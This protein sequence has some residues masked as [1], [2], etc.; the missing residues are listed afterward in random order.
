IQNAQGIIQSSKASKITILTTKQHIIALKKLRAE[1]EATKKA[2][3]IR[4]RKQ[5]ERTGTVRSK[6]IDYDLKAQNQAQRR[7]I[8]LAQQQAN[9]QNQAQ[10]RAIKLAQ[11]QA[12]AQNQ[13]QRRSIKLAQKQ[14]SAMD[15]ASKSIDRQRSAAFKA[16][17]ATKSYGDNVKFLTTRAL[18]VIPVWLALRSA[19]MG[20]LR[21]I[22]ESVTF[23]IDWEFQMAQIRIVSNESESSLNSL[24]N[25]LLSLSASLGI[26]NQELGEASKLYAQQGRSI[27]EILP[28]MAAT[29]K[30]SLLTGRNMTTSVEDMTAC[31]D[32][33]TEILTENGWKNHDEIT[34][35]DNAITKDLSTDKIYYTPVE[36]IFKNKNY[37]GKMAHYNTG[38]FKKQQVDFF[39]TPNHKFPVSYSIYNCIYNRKLKNSIKKQ[40]KKAADFKLMELDKV[41]YKRFHIPTTGIWEGKEI[42][43]INIP[44]FQG[45]RILHKS[46]KFKMD[47]WLEFLGWF[48]SE[49]SCNVTK[50][51]QSTVQIGQSFTKNPEKCVQIR[52]VLERL[53]VPF[54]EY[55]SQDMCLFQVSNRIRNI[56]EWL[57][58]NC[59]T[60][61]IHPNSKTKRIPDFVKNLSPRQINIFLTSYGLGDGTVDKRN[62]AKSYSTSS[63]QLRDDLLD[64]L[65]KIGKTPSYITALPNSKNN[66]TS[67]HYK[68]HSSNKIAH[69]LRRKNIKY[70]DYEGLI[71][72]IEVK[73]HHTIY[74]RRNGK[75]MWSGNTLKAYKLEAN[76][77]D[78]VVDLISNT[79]LHHAITAGDL[80][81]AY[82]ATAS[83]ASALGVS[84]AGLT[85]FI[86]AIKTVTRDTGSKVGLTLRTMFSRI[87]TSSAEAL[88]VLTKVPIFLDSAGKAT[89]RVTPNLR[90]LETVMLELAS[91]FQLLGDA[92]QAQVAKLIGGVRR[93]NQVFALFNNF[94]EA[95][96]AQADAL[97]GL[98]ESDKAVGILTDTMELRIGKLQGAWGQMVNAFTNTD[99]LKSAT[100]LM[101]EYIE[102]VTL[103]VDKAAFK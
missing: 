95:V 99:A 11:Q 72:C 89:T 21:V 45:V 23:L 74:I 80:A 98:G 43:N 51:G 8:K 102:G 78:G 14:K 44:S 96:G 46:Y 62:G 67:D 59:Y 19:F 25:S 24:S 70:V 39:V 77:A 22:K 50:K 26:S 32:G 61:R 30:L 71:W 82:K 79:M 94:T 41:K 40:E 93:Q 3:N 103:A 12:K 17:L 66:L 5:Q 69:H 54:K 49:G 10:R 7:S 53:E 9:A 20:V 13:A 52:E 91:S 85:G 100:G 42:E 58:D 15:R 64:L 86:T 68:I 6:E 65:L 84:L 38:A 28:L 60:D 57:L 101:T 1:I 73:P 37:K 87:T 81:Q 33:Q 18:T 31:F 92:Q 36:Y 47:D 75:C 48:V 90:N 29:A 88:Q 4:V 16:S 97:F 63:P 27:S 55:T 56:V 76:E 35:K 34:L 83:T 2:Q